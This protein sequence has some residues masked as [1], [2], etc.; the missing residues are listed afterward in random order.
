MGLSPPTRQTRRRLTAHGTVPL[1]KVPCAH[2]LDRAQG[3][4]PASLRPGCD[5]SPQ[6][7]K[8]PAPLSTLGQL[9]RVAPAPEPLT[10]LAEASAEMGA[11]AGPPAAQAWRR[12]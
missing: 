8:S 4:A 1:R 5:W 9:G 10:G 7:H 11:A 2:G 12:S 6:G 3:S